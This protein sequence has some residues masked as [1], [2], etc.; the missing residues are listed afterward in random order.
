MSANFAVKIFLLFELAFLK[1]VFSVV[2]FPFFLLVRSKNSEVHNAQS[3]AKNPHHFQREIV[4]S[5]AVVIILVLGFQVLFSS[6]SQ[7]QMFHEAASTPLDFSGSRPSS[8]GESIPV[9][10]VSVS[11]FDQTVTFEGT[12]PSYAHVA[13]ILD[14]GESFVATTQL[15]AQGHWEFTPTAGQG[16]LSAGKH[17][18]FAVFYGDDNKVLGKPTAMKTFVISS[19]TF[20]E[21]FRY[22][23]FNSLI[24]ALLTIGVLSFSVIKLKKVAT[25]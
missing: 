15:D 25:I 14:D 2:A 23:G 7:G 8:E 12:G 21:I 18:V 20:S 4:L 16:M 19:N 17:S 3:L 22:I 1:F 5:F 24:I 6:L 10:D 9:S 11:P 13:I